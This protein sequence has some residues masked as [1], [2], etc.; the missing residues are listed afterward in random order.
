MPSVYA[1]TWDSEILRISRLE[2]VI[3]NGILMERS[4][5]MIAALN[6]E[7]GEVGVMK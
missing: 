7:D 4:E 3:R 6:R 5:G 1:C 2:V